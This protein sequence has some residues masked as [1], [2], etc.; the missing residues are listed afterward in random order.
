MHLP[1]AAATRRGRLRFTATCV[2][3]SCS[4]ERGLKL[5]GG[6]KQRVA[7]GR[8]ILR[9][10]PVLLCDEATSAVDTVTEN[11]IQA[12]LRSRSQRPG[13]TQ[14]VIMIA[15]RLSTVVD[16]DRILVLRDGAV[17]ESGK[18][19]ELLRQGGEYSQLWELQFDELQLKD[20]PARK[21]GG[22]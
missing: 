4:G 10:A 2:L 3:F 11:H 9:D 5:S 13:Q 22:I 18:H 14:T 20:Q 7:I 12:E 8:A 21:D 1:I 16:A 15:H 17:V 6:E 19:T